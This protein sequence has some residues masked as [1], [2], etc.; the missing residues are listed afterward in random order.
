MVQGFKSAIFEGESGLSSGPMTS[1][2]IQLSLSYGEDCIF[3]DFSLELESG[4]LVCLLGKSGSGKSTLLQFIAGLLSSNIA[5]GSV[6][7]DDHKP[8]SGRIAWMA[9]QDLLL[10]W[11]RIIDNITLGALLRGNRTAMHFEIARRLLSDVEL[12]NVENRYPHELSG[13]MRQRVA[14]ARTLAE[15]RPINLLDEPFSGLDAS[16]RYQIQGLATRLLANRTTLLVTHDPLE[17]LRMADLVY[18]LDGRP[19]RVAHPVKPPGDP[20]RQLA[21]SRIGQ[22]YTQL[23]HQL[24]HPEVEGHGP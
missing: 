9:Q 18:V 22:S 2:S 5:Q 7:A 20:P 13:G 21:D 12:E 15:E 14:L 4:K 10:P 23:M 3:D 11:L 1:V 24:S 8:L 16:T 19:A 6:T 17:A